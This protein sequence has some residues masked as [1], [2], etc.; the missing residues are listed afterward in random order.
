MKKRIV[1]S[2]KMI[3]VLAL[4]LGLTLGTVQPAAVAKTQYWLVGPSAYGGGT[5]K[6][7]YKG[8]K[9]TLKGK[10]GKGSTMTKAG[11]ASR[12]KVNKTFKVSKNCKVYEIEEVTK[13]HS[14]DQ[15]MDEVNAKYGKKL[16]FIA[17][18]VRIKGNKITRICFSA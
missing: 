17:G 13:I 6:M 4:A 2:V 7:I 10:W 8:H 3:L 9:I 16:S 5:A 1:S 14:Y 12:K 18:Y 11:N 15:Y